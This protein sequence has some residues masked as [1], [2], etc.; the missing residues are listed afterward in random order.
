MTNLR[1]KLI[2]SQGSMT[3]QSVGTP[4]PIRRRQTMPQVPEEGSKFSLPGGA[5][6]VEQT[7]RRMKQNKARL[8]PHQNSNVR[9]PGL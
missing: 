8:A 5:A 6:K 3:H 2:F 7:M 4:D 9:T 1:L